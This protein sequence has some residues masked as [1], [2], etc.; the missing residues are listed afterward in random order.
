MKSGVVSLV[1]NTNVGKST[2]LNLLSEKKIS[3]VT[4][5]PQTTRDSIFNIIDIDNCRIFLQDTPG[6]IKN[7]KGIL[8]KKM[9]DIAT[10]A[11]RNSDLIILV[12]NYND[13]MNFNDFF[14]KN[15]VKIDIVV[16]NKIDLIKLEQA[17]NLRKKVKELFPHSDFIEMS[18]INGFNKDLLLSSIIKKLPENS[19]DK[20]VFLL[21][22]EDF[23]YK[24][25]IRKKIFIFLEKEIPYT[26]AVVIEKISNENGKEIVFAKIVVSREAHKKIIIGSN[27]NMIKKIRISSEKE[28]KKIFA[29]KV[30]LEIFVKV[31]DWLKSGNLLKKYGY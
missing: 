20:N 5:K 24:E 18:A 30:K 28:I 27:G 6:F 13:L 9:I 11:L 17:D 19:H 3:I 4:H 31:E 21:K 25:I 1:G 7:A 26:T 23:F 14:L 22:K 15:L 16:L 8:A 12:L 2:I 29:K 10:A